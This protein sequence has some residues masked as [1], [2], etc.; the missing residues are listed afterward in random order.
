M[1]YTLYRGKVEG[2]RL[3][4]ENNSYVIRI[5]PLMEEI[6]ETEMLP[7]FPSFFS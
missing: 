4:E 6:Q 5:L 2:L 1:E 3:K 7:L